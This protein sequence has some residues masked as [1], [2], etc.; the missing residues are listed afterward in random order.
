MASSRAHRPTTF[1]C[2]RTAAIADVLARLA[3]DRSVGDV[4]D[5]LDGRSVA[6]PGD[7][8]DGQRR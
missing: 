7:V 6:E 5:R 3:P 8:A 1:A 2:G 4:A